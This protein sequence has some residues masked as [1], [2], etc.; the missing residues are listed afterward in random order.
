VQ[1]IENEAKRKWV[2]PTDVDA[3]VAADMAADLT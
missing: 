1:R 2:P 3:D